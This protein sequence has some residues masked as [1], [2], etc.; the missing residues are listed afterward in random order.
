MFFAKNI[1][2]IIEFSRCIGTYSSVKFE[3]I[4]IDAIYDT[5]Y[6]NG[7]RHQ[8]CQNGISF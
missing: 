5:T 7:R 3:L 1:L 6:N 8:T 2:G 4:I